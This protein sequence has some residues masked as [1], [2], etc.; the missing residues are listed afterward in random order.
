MWIDLN[1]NGQYDVSEMLVSTPYSYTTKTGN[2]TIPV[3]ATPA[4]NVRMRIRTATSYSAQW[5]GNAA[6]TSYWGNYGYGETE[7]YYVNLISPCQGPVITSQPLQQLACP[8]TSATFTVA[9]TSAATYKWQVGTALTG[10]YTDITDNS[11]YAGSGTAM[12]TINNMPPAFNGNYYRC[13]TVS[14]CGTPTNSNGAKLSLHTDVT[15]ASTS[16][17]ILTCKNS[18]RSVSI[19]P[20]PGVVSTYRWQMGTSTGGFWDVPAAYPYVGVNAGQMDIT[21]V[22]DTMNGKSFRCIINGPCSA[23][24]SA[25]IAIDVIQGPYISESPINDTI[26]PYTTASFTVVPKKFDYQLSWQASADNGATF[27]TIN[28][29][30]LYSGNNLDILYVYNAPPNLTGM[31]FRCILKSTNPTCGLYYDTSGAATLYVGNFGGLAVKD[32][33]AADNS[34]SVF[35]NPAIGGE[36]HL[37]MKNPVQGDVQLSIIDKLGKTVY[38]G[39]TNLSKGN[40]TVPVAQL[41]PGVY[42]IKL[43][44]KDDNPLDNIQ[45]TKQ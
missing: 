6:C 40:A 3:T 17:N 8:G 12:L 7:D 23:D 42:S 20:G 41:V 27:S 29:N 2:V 28:N 4:T 19:T 5:P 35:P 39:S 31:Q 25:D 45:F 32:K 13:R 30:S 16:A 44:D 33:D 26:L 38:K 43:A 15:V 36:V 10:P 37:A 24:T 14:G 9:A 22:M 34:L 1:N 18:T 11:N 21:T